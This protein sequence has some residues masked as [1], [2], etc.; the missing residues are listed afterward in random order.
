MAVTA[1]PATHIAD[2][3]LLDADG[4]VELFKIQPLSGGTVYIK[5]GND[6]TWQGQVWAGL[7]CGISGLKRTTESSSMQP[8]FSLGQPNIDLSAF[9]PLVHD[10]Y[11]DG[12][13][14][15]YYR[16][17]LTHLLTNTNISDIKIFR[18]KRVVTYSRS[19]IMLDLSSASD[20]MMFTLPNLQYYPPAFPAV[21]LEI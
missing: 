17:L 4:V 9:K 5:P 11:L 15:T 21:M 18:I 8:R 10:G 12:A 7:P 2:A 1:I 20:A 14:F 13:T 6:A 3:Q 16:V 19:Q